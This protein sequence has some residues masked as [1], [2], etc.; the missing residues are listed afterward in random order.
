MIKQIKRSDLSTCNFDKWLLSLKQK[1]LFSSNNLEYEIS[2]DDLGKVSAAIIEVHTSKYMLISH[3]EA[4]DNNIDVFL[5]IDTPVGELTKLAND[6]LE[7]IYIS[8][9]ESL[10]FNEEVSLDKLDHW[11][12]NRQDDNGAKNT[13]TTKL[14][15]KA[16]LQLADSFEKK[17]HK[18]MYWVE[19]T[20]K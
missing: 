16:A 14:S 12:V 5:D 11:N 3:S 18:Q 13:I 20:Q 17:G 10:E 6:L 2:N 1:D 9:E 8:D 7:Y 4:P 19:K 15:K